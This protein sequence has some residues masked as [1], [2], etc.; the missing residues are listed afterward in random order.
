MR[1][2]RQRLFKHCSRACFLQT[3]GKRRR[4]ER[5]KWTF[6]SRPPRCQWS[7]FDRR[8]R[9]QTRKF[10]DS[11]KDSFITLDVLFTWETCIGLCKQHNKFA[12][13]AYA[14]LYLKM[15][16]RKRV[17]THDIRVDPGVAI[18]LPHLNLSAILAHARL[19]RQC[20]WHTIS[21]I[22]CASRQH[23][24]ERRGNTAVQK[25]LYSH[26][27]QLLL[28]LRLLYAC[29]KSAQGLRAPTHTQKPRSHNHS[30]KKT[31]KLLIF[32]FPAAFAIESEE[33]LWPAWWIFFGSS[34]Y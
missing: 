19:G 4:V 20:S 6:Y 23:S 26:F 33:I 29:Y 2:K 34:F 5:Q 24:A 18:D 31:R 13:S 3:A 14:P 7:R 30:F 9:R 25:H 10:L 12:V 8:R 32:L 15:R 22:C 16:F 21:I 11:F 28:L 1:K 27:S 17:N